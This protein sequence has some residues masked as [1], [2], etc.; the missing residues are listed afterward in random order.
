MVSPHRAP[1]MVLRDL[2]LHLPGSVVRNGTSRYP[3]LHYQ[4]SRILWKQHRGW[5]EVFTGHR[6]A[7]ATT[8]IVF[9]DE[10]ALLLHFDSLKPRAPAAPTCPYCK[11]EALL[12]DRSEMANSPFASGKVY[13]CARYPACDA[14][15]GAE[16]HSL[17]P[18]GTLANRELRSLRQSVHQAFDPLWRGKSPAHRSLA[19]EAASVAIG[20]QSFHIGMS[21]EATC[22]KVL[23]HIE[24]IAKR[25]DE[26]LQVAQLAL[27]TARRQTTLPLF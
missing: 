8:P 12:R 23:A 26:K 3:V 21:D 2:S 13:A 19:Y 10:T 18:L 9:R 4:S 5:F 25:V 6:D 24:H 14:Y 16:A 11:S 27:Q 22:H 1:D 15:V 20:V 17:E 7:G